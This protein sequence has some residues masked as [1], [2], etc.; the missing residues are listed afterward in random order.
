RVF[1]TA[2]GE[3]L[4]SKAGSPDGALGHQMV[5][6]GDVNGDTVPDIAVAE[7]HADPM[8]VNSAGTVHVLSGDTGATIN[9]IH[10]IR[11]YQVLG[12]AIDVIADLNNDGYN[13]LL[14]GDPGLYETNPF[15]GNVQAISPADGTVILTLTANLPDTGFGTRVASAGDLDGDQLADIIV[16]SGAPFQNE[17]LAA[18]S[19][20][21][22]LPLWSKQMDLP[23]RMVSVDDM[24]D[25]G[26]ADLV[27]A[28]TVIFPIT[29]GVADLIDGATGTVFKTIGESSSNGFSSIAA[30]GD[31]N[32]DGKPELFAAVFGPGFNYDPYAEMFSLPDAAS[33][34]TITNPSG[35]D[36]L[37]LG[38]GVAGDLDGD[39]KD[40]YILSSSTRLMVFAGDGSGPILDETV[41]TP[42]AQGDAE[43]MGFDDLTGDGIPEIFMANGIWLS[44]S[45]PLGR[46]LILSGA[47]GSIV[48]EMIGNL[49]S[50]Y[51]GDDIAP[52]ID[53]NNDGVRDF[54]VSVTGQKVDGKVYVGEVRLLSGATRETLHVYRTAPQEYGWFGVSVSAGGDVDEDGIPDLGVGSGI[55][56]LPPLGTGTFYV[57]SGATGEELYHIDG[58]PGSLFLYGNIIDD[59]NGD[60]VADFITSEPDWTHPN[61][62]PHSD[63]GRV[64]AWSGKDG[65]LLWRVEGTAKGDQFGWAAEGAGD[66]NGDGYTDVAVSARYGGTGDLGEFVLISGEDGSILDRTDLPVYASSFASIG[67]FDPGASADVIVGLPDLDNNGGARLY[68]CSQGG[69]HGFKDLG[70]AL[71]G[72]NPAAPQLKG[73]GGLGG[74]EE[75]SLKVRRV[76]PNAPGYWFF[77]FDTAYLP[78]KGGVFVPEPYGILFVFPIFADGNGEYAFSAI[79]PPDLPAGTMLVHQ[80]WF[81]DAGAVLGASA[82][83]GLAEIFK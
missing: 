66:V 1:S 2:T 34:Y 63:R 46:L 83:N 15:Y 43:V 53:R 74:G 39:E 29:F 73:Y 59:A 32:N 8:G 76:L 13:D 58:G 28:R 26:I 33:L 38:V 31:L 20:A 71:K 79:T 24:N 60:G 77:S 5:P 47:D 52:T 68:A 37:G 65:S 51:F 22:L 64:R 42:S 61:D 48:D 41:G 82:T 4:W 56:L 57:L 67:S 7:Q 44:G 21:T 30:P 14:L 72:T 23:G 36:L 69:V 40:D 11:V 6:L 80:F 3:E 35:G 81:Y 16:G 27:S 50:Q 10:G 9:E 19:S 62:P 49:Q 12:A 54:F 25:D 18:Y 45:K 75:S 78:F 70:N 55:D 17:Y